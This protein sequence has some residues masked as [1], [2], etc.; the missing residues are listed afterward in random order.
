[1][2]RFIAELS[3]SV[4]KTDF[5]RSW[6][7]DPALNN[8]RPKVEFVFTGRRVSVVIHSE[9]STQWPSSSFRQAFSGVIRRLDRICNVRWL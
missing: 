9:P 8:N 6:Q 1:V 5:E 4:D 2:Q 3:N 7:S